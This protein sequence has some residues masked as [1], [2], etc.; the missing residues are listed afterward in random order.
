M[1]EPCSNSLGRETGDASSSLRP[2]RKLLILSINARSICNKF[3]SFVSLVAYYNPAIVA[4]T[5]T[6]LRPD[7]PGIF[8]K[9]YSCFRSDRPF[10]LG[11][12][13]LL[14]IQ[15]SFSPAE[16]FVQSPSENIFRDSTW[17]TLSIAKNLS[18][19]VGCVY[20]SPSSDSDNNQSLNKLISTACDMPQCHKIILGDFNFPDIEWDDLSGKT[21]S[22]SFRIMINDC[23]LTQIV[24]QPTRG[25]SILDLVLSNDPSIFDSVEVIEPP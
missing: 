1:P 21:S 25:S 3:D 17:C 19:L 11:G 12:G 18:L 9:G 23:F 8:V 10:G 14:L 24:R 13:T 20:R 4:V 16:I 7:I 6:W 5:E 2:K 15:S 22:E